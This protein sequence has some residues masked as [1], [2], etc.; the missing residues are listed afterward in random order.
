[1]ENSFGDEPT[2]DA[3][4]NRGSHVYAFKA[5][6]RLGQYRIIRV[7][8]AGGMGE[9]YEVE[10]ATLERRY[11]LKLLPEALDWRGVSLERFKRE[12]KVMANLEHP[13]I[14]KV[15]EFG[16]VDGRYWLRME[17]VEGVA[18]SVGRD[19]GPVAVSL[20]DLADAGGGKVPQETLLPIL[21]QVLEGLQYAH[22]HGAIHRD[23]KPSNI[24]LSYPT[25]EHRSL[26]TIQAKIADFGLV[27]LVGEE[28]V[29]SQAQLSVQQSISMGD[30]RTVG[31]T[32]DVGAGTSTRALL[33]TYEYM[34]PEQKRSEEADERSDVYSVGL[35]AF[36]LLTGRNPGTKPP[37]RIDSSLAKGWDEFVEQA[38]EEDRDE[39]LAS[40]V[41]ALA[42]LN[43]LG[44]QFDVAGREMEEQQ[45]REN[46]ERQRQQAAAERRA[47]A[48]RKAREQ[49]GQETAA[50]A[51]STKRRT[52]RWLLGLLI[53]IAGVLI[54][55]MQQD[56]P[57]SSAPAVRQSTPQP[58][59]QPEPQPAPQPEPQ[60]APQPE[61]QPAPQPTP[62]PTPQPASSQPPRQSERS[63]IPDGFVQVGERIDSASRLPMAIRHEQTDYV[64]RLVPAGEFDLGSP[65]GEGFDD[66]RPRRRI[67]L[68]PYWIGETP[69]TC[70]QFVHF[71][72]ERGNQTEGGVSWVNFG[73]AIKIER[74]GTA[75]RAKSGFGEHP[76]VTVS[77]F[78]ARAFARWL[79]GDL[80]SEVQWEK[81]ARGGRD[82]RWPW[83]DT[84]HSSRANTA[85]RIAG[86]AEFTTYADWLQWWE[87][88]QRTVL[89]RSDG[90]DD[91]TTAVKSYAANGYGLYDMAGNV[92]DWCLD[93]YVPDAYRQLRDGQR[94]PPPPAS[95]EPQDVTYWQGGEQKTDRQPCRVVRGGGWGYSATSTRCAYRNWDQPTGWYTSAGCR[96]VVS[97]RP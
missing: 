34:S 22:G 72:N 79:G 74:F 27:R 40:A 18:C 77:W 48:D 16:E 91:T 51:P 56:G 53:G 7:L 15:D 62:Q 30:V 94:N 8:G 52:G 97:P 66:E 76:V 85:E 55:G 61:P 71:L 26:N 78:G 4:R 42:L 41:D 35:M 60:P 88:Y 86:V 1:M 17:L 96:V 57:Q 59:P 10:H 39:R 9:V 46:E 68:D 80:P 84:W 20:Q 65:P 73:R 14:L 19:Q 50:A 2:L 31:G 92:R 21:R 6:H 25:T 49:A 23:L 45:K 37:S 44:R 24:L 11:A 70:S 3:A 75:F 67:Y 83:G 43:K 29:R 32:P 12:A 64:L 82:V 90:Y 63:R 58:A 81:A 5:G 69:V 95:G 13:N 93:W 36:R 28:W 38:L 54:W 87:P 33:G 47:A 89:Q